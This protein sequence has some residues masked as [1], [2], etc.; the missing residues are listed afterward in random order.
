MS[1]QHITGVQRWVLLEFRVYDLG[2]HRLR[3]KFRG[4]GSERTKPQM[5]ASCASFS[6]T[7]LKVSGVGEVLSRSRSPSLSLSVSLSLSP[8]PLAYV[9]H[10]ASTCRMLSPVQTCKLLIISNEGMSVCIITPPPPKQE[11]DCSII[12]IYFFV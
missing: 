11:L 6:R 8:P 7:N 4:P 1:L 12:Y 10:R 5:S 9:S 3:P 2:L